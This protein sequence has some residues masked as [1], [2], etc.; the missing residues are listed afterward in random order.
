MDPRGERWWGDLESDLNGIF[1]GGGA[2]GVLYAGAVAAVAETGHWFRAVCGASAGAITATLIAA[3]VTPDAFPAEAARGLA[4]IQ[5]NYLFDLAGR[6]FVVTR[7]L[8]SWLEDLLRAQVGRFTTTPPAATPVTFGDLFA[9]TGIELYVVCVDVAT[10][11]PLVFGTPLT[12]DL[13]VTDAVI[14]SSSIPFA[15][16]PGRLRVETPG[17]LEVHRLMDGGVWANYP[18]F[19]FRDPSFRAHHGLAPLPEST[20]VGFA[21]AQPVA[22]GAVRGTPL[23]LLKDAKGIHS[24]LGSGLKGWLRNPLVRLYFLTLVPLVMALQFFWT[25]ERYGLVF[26][27]ETVGMS[28]LPGPI[29][30]AAGYFDGFFS[31]FGPG[32]VTGALVVA[33]VAVAMMFFG[34]TVID[35]AAPAIRTLMAVG[36]GVPYWSGADPRDHVVRIVIPPGLGTFSFTLKEED[37]TRL[38]EDARTQVRAQL[39]LI[40]SR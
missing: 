24:D 11:Q 28:T 31:H 21:L 32:Y 13:S 1:Q 34:A 15:F 39:D 37:R 25:T 7:K 29:V 8:Q 3:G 40:V 23:T 27:Q 16:A 26:L 5:R 2:K 6:P 9:A 35:S 20:T 12:P 22:S 10:R 33:L 18:A 14:A 17:G 36:T 30:Q 19:V 38:V 4:S